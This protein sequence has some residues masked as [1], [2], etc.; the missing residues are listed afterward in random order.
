MILMFFSFVFFFLAAQKE[1]LVQPI[2]T[3]YNSQITILF[4]KPN[5]WSVSNLSF[6]IFQCS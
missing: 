6:F 4:N 1:L 3:N 2:F 5:S